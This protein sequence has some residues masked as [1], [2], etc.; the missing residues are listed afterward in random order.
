M[1]NSLGEIVLA[2]VVVALIAGWGFDH[3]RQAAII[4]GLTKQ[5]ENFKKLTEARDATKTP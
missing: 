1:K 3:F 2:F 4:D 5:Q